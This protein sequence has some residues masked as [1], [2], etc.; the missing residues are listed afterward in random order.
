MGDISDIM[1][2]GNVSFDIGEGVNM[3]LVEK[4]V[5][6]P[7][8]YDRGI[9]KEEINKILNGL[10][11]E[12]NGKTI[13]FTEKTVDMDGIQVN[14]KTGPNQKYTEGN[15]FEVCICICCEKKS[16]LISRGDAVK[17]AK[18]I[19]EQAG[20]LRVQDFQKTCY[21]INNLLKSNSCKLV[22]VCIEKSWV[23]TY[24]KTK[25]ISAVNYATIINNLSKW[26]DK[27]GCWVLYDGK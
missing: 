1:V 2:R 17:M 23:D 25:T 24:K 21:G 16:N 7:T 9:I 14:T 19:R 15:P 12:L 26:R 11:V 8:I 5:S 3:W 22:I 18:K 6:I 10:S 27:E 4:T 20:D 13:S